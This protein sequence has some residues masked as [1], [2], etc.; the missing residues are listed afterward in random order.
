MVRGSGDLLERMKCDTK[1]G[2]LRKHLDTM[3]RRG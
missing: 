3:L 2:D 1:A